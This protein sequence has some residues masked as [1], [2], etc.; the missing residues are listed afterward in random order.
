MFNDYR[1]DTALEIADSL[2]SPQVDKEKT[3][4]YHFSLNLLPLL[5]RNCG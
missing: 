3:K 5:I 4:N 2:V 1:Y